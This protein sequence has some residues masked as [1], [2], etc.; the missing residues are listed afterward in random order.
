MLQSTLGRRSVVGAR[1]AA[2]RWMGGD[3]PVPQSQ[4][5]P[6]W[7]G[8]AVK[9][10]GWETSMYF[11]AAASIILQGAIVMGA[12][13]TSIES[14]AR[15]E[16]Q[17]RL[18]LAEQGFTDFEFGKHYQDL[19]KKASLD[20]FDK[21]AARSTIPGEEDD[22]DDDDEDEEDEDDEEVCSGLDLSIA[23]CVLVLNTY[24]VLLIN[25]SHTE[26]LLSLLG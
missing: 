10:E 7:H 4:N 1:N 3:M 20:I 5:A 8:H 17:A 26:L 25:L 12:P 23:E 14:W 18:R 16:A 2:R 9:E 13:E 15:P 24:C 19:E 6:L 21:F 22:D 11:Y